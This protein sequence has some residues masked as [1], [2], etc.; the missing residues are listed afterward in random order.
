VVIIDA[1]T[2]GRLVDEEEEEEEDEVEEEE[3]FSF[4]L[5]VGFVTTGISS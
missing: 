1:G 2:T 5:K 4:N 3:N